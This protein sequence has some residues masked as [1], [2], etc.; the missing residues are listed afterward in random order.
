MAS[1]QLPGEV[2]QHILLLLPAEHM[3]VV[4]LSCSAWCR[5][6]LSDD[7]MC[8]PICLKL[9]NS[10]IPR[11]VSEAGMQQPWR[12][13]L[14]QL[15]W[16]LRSLVHVLLRLPPRGALFSAMLCC[17]LW[18]RLCNE[19]FWMAAYSRRWPRAASAIVHDPVTTGFCWRRRYRERHIY[20]G[21]RF[22][23]GQSEDEEFWR[24]SYETEEA[25]HRAL[26]ASLKEVEEER[27]RR[28]PL[29]E[30]ETDGAGEP[31]DGQWIRGI[32]REGKCYLYIH[33]ITHEVRGAAVCTD[34][35]PQKIVLVVVTIQ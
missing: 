9:Q 34:K 11:A 23:L 15:N 5:D 12:R 7:S 19:H 13:C 3:P 21:E 32:N 8:R 24:A 33:T 26:V 16:R 17:N 20:C 6:L 29:M 4:L 27:L 28:F 10:G 31:L 30:V 35:I 22:Q 14:I 18:H 25:Y 2:V 1:Q